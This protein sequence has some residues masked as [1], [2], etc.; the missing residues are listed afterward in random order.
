MQFGSTVDNSKLT[1]EFH[2]NGQGENATDNNNQQVVDN[3]GGNVAPQNGQATQPQDNQ[4]TEGIKIGEEVFDNEQALVEA[5]QS[6]KA[7]LENRNKSYK[8]LQA[9][10]TKSR[11]EISMRNKM[12]TPNNNRQSVQPIIPQPMP[13][14][15]NP[16][17]PYA[18]QINN[19]YAISNRPNVAVPNYNQYYN[20]QVQQ[21][22]IVNEA[23]INM[24]AESKIIELKNSDPNFEEVAGEL[25]NIMDTD[26]YFANIKFTDPD[27]AKNAISAAYQMAK[28]KIETAKANIKV[29]NARQE[30][31]NGKQQKLLNNDNSNVANKGKNKVEE[32]TDAEKIKENILGAKPLTF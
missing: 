4:S 7:E 14:M 24:A 23:M 28:Q 19:P 31:Y 1:P 6:M 15:V 20:P 10:Y 21:A 25:W 29:N 27:M 32:K 16:I 30:A 11:Q 18:S 17:N 5:Y 26:P 22:P 2:N 13:N 12:A 8:S 9:E 3:Q